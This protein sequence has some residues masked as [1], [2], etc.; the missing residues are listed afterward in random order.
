MQRG[1]S[2]TFDNVRAHVPDLLLWR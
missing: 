1:R 2:L